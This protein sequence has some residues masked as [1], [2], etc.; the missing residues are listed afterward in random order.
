MPAR[1]RRSS[2]QERL[3]RFAYGA[4]VLATGLMLLGVLL[5]RAS[6]P[7]AAATTLLVA[8]GGFKVSLH[9]LTVVVSGVL[10]VALVGEGLRRLRLG[11]HLFRG[12]G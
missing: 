12:K 5:L 2:R 4:A 9:T 1:P 7:P 11:S 3:R 6:H 8:L 10:I